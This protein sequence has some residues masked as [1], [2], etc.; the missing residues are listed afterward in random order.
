LIKRQQDEQDDRRIGRY[1]VRVNHLGVHAPLLQGLGGDA[2]S[3][4]QG[5]EH[6]LE[7]VRGER[8]GERERIRMRIRWG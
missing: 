8:E 2:G 4:A 3:Q 7:G 5:A 1:N 6:V